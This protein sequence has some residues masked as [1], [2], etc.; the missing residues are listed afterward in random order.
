MWRLISFLIF[1]RYVYI[2]FKIVFY[3]EN[4]KYRLYLR[5]IIKENNIDY[6]L[7]FSFKYFYLDVD[8]IIFIKGKVK[9]VWFFFFVCIDWI[10]SIIRFDFNGRL[11][12]INRKDE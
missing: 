12:F 1:K 2:C 3:K 10:G 5:I 11:W 4:R 8:L 9:L 6:F 7:I